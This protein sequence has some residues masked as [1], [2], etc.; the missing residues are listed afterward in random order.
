M[1][2]ENHVKGELQFVICDENNDM[3]YLC[4]GAVREALGITDKKSVPEPEPP[5]P[6]PPAV[7]EADV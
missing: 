1:S 2:H 7:E 5:E 6:T 4:A 3:V